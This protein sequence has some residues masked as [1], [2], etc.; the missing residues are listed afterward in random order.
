MVEHTRIEGIRGPDS[1][2]TPPLVVVGISHDETCTLNCGGSCRCPR[3]VAPVA[4]SHA[5]GPKRLPLHQLI[6][7]VE[8][9]IENLSSAIPSLIAKGWTVTNAEYQLSMLENVRD[10]LRAVR[11]EHPD[12][13]EFKRWVSDHA[14]DAGPTEALLRRDWER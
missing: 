13:A 9:E 5:R 14:E 12:E 3:I 2:D 8:R 7:G 6:H 11:A 1:C 10:V 4:L